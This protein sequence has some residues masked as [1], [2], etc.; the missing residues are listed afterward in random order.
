MAAASLDYYLHPEKIPN[1]KKVSELSKEEAAE[2]IEYWQTHWIFDIDTVTKGL[3]LTLG[4]VSLKDEY[5]AAKRSIDEGKPVILA[6]FHGMVRHGSFWTPV[7]HNVVEYNYKETDEKIEGYI[8]DSNYRLEERVINKTW[9]NGELKMNYTSAG[10][11]FKSF[12]SL[13][14]AVDYSIWDNMLYI[15]VRCPVELHVYDSQGNHI[16]LTPEGVETGFP[17]LYIHDEEGELALIPGHEGN[18]TIEIVGTGE[19]TYN[20]SI[21]AVFD[22]TIVVEKNISGKVFPDATYNYKISISPAEIVVEET[23][24]TAQTT[25]VPEFTTIL[26]PVLIIFGLFQLMRWA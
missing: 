14:S 1:G 3:Q 13:G 10:Y 23:T 25:P 5:Q 18:Y 8:Y 4:F 24:D 26:I 22:G 16:G 2:D 17:A 19:G 15:L 6:M 11:D 12:V 9:K 7:Y 21:A 20:L